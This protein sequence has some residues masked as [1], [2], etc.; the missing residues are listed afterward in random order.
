MIKFIFFLRINISRSRR[1]RSKLDLSFN[2]NRI[3]GEKKRKEKINHRFNLIM[4]LS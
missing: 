2:E 1:I 3:D 4:Q